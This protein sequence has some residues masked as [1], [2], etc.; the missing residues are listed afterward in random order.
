MKSYLW[1]FVL[2]TLAVGILSWKPDPNPKPI[3]GSSQVRGEDT[4]QVRQFLRD[5][6][7][8]VEGSANC[9]RFEV[10]SSN[11]RVCLINSRLRTCFL[12]NWIQVR[13]L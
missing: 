12:L 9:A 6:G 3:S 10:T 13:V 8:C 7:K 4:I 5:N 11:G 1:L 2:C